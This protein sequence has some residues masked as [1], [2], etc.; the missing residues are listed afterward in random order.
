M[1]IHQGD[2]YSLSEHQLAETVWSNDNQSGNDDGH[3]IDGDL[4]D[5]K[6]RQRRPKAAQVVAHPPR[7]PITVTLIYQK[8]GIATMGSNIQ[9]SNCPVLWAVAPQLHSK[10][11]AYMLCFFQGS[12][13]PYTS[14]LQRHAAEHR[15]LNNIDGRN[16]ACLL[17]HDPE[18]CDLFIGYSKDIHVGALS[19]LNQHL[20]EF[21][22]TYDQLY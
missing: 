3:S 8:A 18:A 2:V 1:A 16:L 20:P 6:R 13:L 10:L 9:A 7:P 17:I 12:C 4:T 22:T 11:R 14:G 19:I 21:F 5:V 15:I